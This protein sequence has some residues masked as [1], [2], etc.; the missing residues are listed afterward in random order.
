MQGTGGVALFGLQ[1]E[2]PG[3]RGLRHLG[4]RREAGTGEGARRRPRGGAGRLGRGR[5]PPHRGP[6][7]RTRPG[8]RRRRPPRPRAGGRGIRG[9]RIGDRA[10]RRLRGVGTGAAPPAQVGDRAGD[11]RRPPPRPGGSR[12]RRRCHRAEARDRPA[13]PGRRIAGRPRPPRPRPLRQG[14]GRNGYTRAAPAASPSIGASVPTGAR[15]LPAAACGMAGAMA[16]PHPPPYRP[17]GAPRH[18]PPP[19][20]HSPGNASRQ[21]STDRDRHPSADPTGAARNFADAGP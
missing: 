15:L 13:L 5:V 4:Q 3:R 18:R 16:H 12:A 1:I 10:P 6:R 21:A 14:R 9:P 19:I 2:G 7:D 11:Q 20:S 17:T 8:D